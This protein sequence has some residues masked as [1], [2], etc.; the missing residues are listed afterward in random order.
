MWAPDHADERDAYFGVSS[1]GRLSGGRRRIPY[2]GPFMFA[3]W[4][5]GNQR[6]YRDLG[7]C[8][9]LKP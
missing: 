7:Y 3:G 9:A 6:P 8:R 5:P 1:V 2:V 4:S